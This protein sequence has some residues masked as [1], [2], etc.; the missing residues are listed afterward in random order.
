MLKVNNVVD[1]NEFPEAKKISLWAVV[2]ANDKE[3]LI[4]D[5]LNPGDRVEIDSGNGIASF[6]DTNMKPLKSIITIAQAAT[7]AGAA[8]LT[9]GESL[10]LHDQF[11]MSF[12]AIKDAIPDNIKHA[13]RD[14]WGQDPGTGDYAKH[15]GGLIVCMPSAHGAIYATEENYLASGA[16]QN[17]RQPKYFSNNINRLNSF[18][19]CMCRGGIREAICK[20]DGAINILAFDSKF[21]DNAGYYE[22]NVDIT[23][24]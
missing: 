6:K 24:K 17:G 2:T 3:G 1:I 5:G 21:T 12:D 14:A 22:F 19:P 16:K 4:I 18:F 8:V 23:R 10:A 11:Q 20:E 7:E 9:E 13:R 15:E